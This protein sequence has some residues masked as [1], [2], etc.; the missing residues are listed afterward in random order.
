MCGQLYFAKWLPCKA[1]IFPDR[2]TSRDRAIGARCPIE[3]AS[4]VYR[5]PKATKEFEA[6]IRAQ[7]ETAPQTTAVIVK[8]GATSLPPGAEFAQPKSKSAKKNAARKAEK[9]KRA[10]AGLP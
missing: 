1:G 6:R 2:G 4:Q 8:S 5:P 7:R 3:E 10:A 9:Q